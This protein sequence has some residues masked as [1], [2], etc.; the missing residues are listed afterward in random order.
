MSLR[1]SAFQKRG[2]GFARWIGDRLLRSIASGGQLSVSRTT[3]R[4][5]HRQ[6]QGTVQSIEDWQKLYAEPKP[7]KPSVI[8][9]FGWQ[10]PRGALVCYRE[11]YGGSA[12]NVGLKLPADEVARGIVSRETIGRAREEINYSVLDPAAFASDGGP[13][14][15]ERMARES[16][17]FRPADNRRVGVRGTMGG[18]DPITFPPD[19]PGQQANVLCVFD[20][21]KP[22]S[23]GCPHC[24]MMQTDPR[25]LTAP[26]TIMPAIRRGTPACHGLM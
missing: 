18:W 26:A 15:A 4:G 7:Q 23:D 22:H 13:S 21:H 25:T 12:P 19:R 17:R 5:Q 2:Y 20:L 9:A 24:S 1:R 10:L 6:R 11:W 3:T 14:I 16:V 8:P